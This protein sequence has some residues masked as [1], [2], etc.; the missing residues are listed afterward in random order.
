MFGVKHRYRYHTSAN[1]KAKHSVAAAIIPP[2]QSGSHDNKR[3]D[4][5]IN[6][7]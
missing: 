5:H 6:T 3:L 7:V 4:M 1:L 2:S